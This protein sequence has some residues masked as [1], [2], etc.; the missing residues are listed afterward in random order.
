MRSKLYRRIRMMFIASIAMLMALLYVSYT[1]PAHAS[2][3]V[4]LP[5]ALAGHPYVQQWTGAQLSSPAWANPQN[6]PGNCPANP[7]QVHHLS[8]GNVE[9]WTSGKSG[10]CTSIQSPVELPS[11]NGYIYEIRFGLSASNIHNWPAYWGYGNSWPSQGEI[12]AY[13]MQFRTNYV[14]W[15]YAPCNSNT[16]SSVKSTDP[17]SYNC[18]TNLRAVG[19]NISTGSHII[20]IAFTSNS[21]QVYYDG[22]LYT[23]APEGLTGT[24]HDPFWITVSEGSCESAGNSVCNSPSDLGIAANLQVN[25]IREF[26]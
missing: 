11:G 22:H 21:V 2:A 14:S 6:A 9:L 5:S 10:N 17:W 4:P 18:K 23:T 13:E 3:P 25:Y 12:D 1:A 7:A 26:K 8:N 15:H 20:D 16:S 24:G 19:A